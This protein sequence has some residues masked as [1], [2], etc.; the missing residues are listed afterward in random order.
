MPTSEPITAAQKWDT[1]YRT[2]MAAMD[3]FSGTLKIF[4]ALDAGAVV[5]FVNLLAKMHEPALVLI[6]LDLSIF[7][8]GTAAILTVP[9]FL[10]LA[11]FHENLAIMIANE[12]QGVTDWQGIYKRDV[13]AWEK[14]YGNKLKWMGRIFDAGVV[15]A[16]VFVLVITFAR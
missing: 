14:R 6:P 11:K 10:S 4:F 7:S 3:G 12:A 8:F 5:L 2:L 16:G 9:A 15:F 13:E 1:F